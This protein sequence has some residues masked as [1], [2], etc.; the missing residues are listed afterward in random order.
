MKIEC[1][2]DT[3]VLVYAAMGRLDEAGKHAIAIDIITTTEFALS[4]QVI[5]EFC[6]KC[7]QPGRD[8]TPLPLGELEEWLNMLGHF[9]STPVDMD[10]ARAAVLLRSRYRLGYYDAQIIAAANRVSAP[11]LY[12]EDLNHG[13]TYGSV[14]VVNPFKI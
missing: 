1:F 2:L 9:P 10:L 4:G 7:L 6:K 14:R 13:Q 3:N 12:S 8:A 11:I 5:A